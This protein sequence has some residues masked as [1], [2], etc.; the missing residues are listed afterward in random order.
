MIKSVS[1]NKKTKA[2]YKELVE[3]LL[4]IEDLKKMP[5]KV[6][7]L[8]GI[9]NPETVAGHTLSLVFMAWLF[10][11]KQKKLDLEKLLKMAL[12]HEITSVYTGDLITPYRKIDDKKVS[13]KEV[14]QKWPRLFKKEKEKQFIQDYKKERKALQKMTKN[15]SAPLRDEFIDLFDDYKNLNSAE[16]RFLNQLN[17]L[18]VLLKGIQYNQADSNI[19]IDFLWEW[20]FEKCDSNDCF[21]FIEE[22]KEK[23]YKENKKSKK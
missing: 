21:L 20:V 22:L 7:A 10:G 14:F 15:L 6:W 13:G 2:E 1:S 4:K 8:M 3:F 11:S 12:C 16:A 17:V 5:R 9:E 23:F 18:A 19:S